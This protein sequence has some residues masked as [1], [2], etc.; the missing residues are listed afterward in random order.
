[1]QPRVARGVICK[2]DMFIDYT[3]VWEGRP[4]PLIGNH[5]VAYSRTRSFNSVF[6]PC[7]CVCISLLRGCKRAGIIMHFAPCFSCRVSLSLS[8]S[9]GEAAL[10][11][12]HFHKYIESAR[13]RR[14]GWCALCVLIIERLGGVI[15][16]RFERAS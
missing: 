14:G 15:R 9:R 10:N 4:D 2:T 1:M 5:S 8:L 7:A 13:E 12:K 6:P 16:W 11:Y 3:A